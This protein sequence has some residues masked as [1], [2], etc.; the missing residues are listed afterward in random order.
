[1]LLFM[2]WVNFVICTILSQQMNKYVCWK[3][4]WVRMC[5]ILETLLNQDLYCQPFGGGIAG[6]DQEVGWED[7]SRDGTTRRTI[8]I[9]KKDSSFSSVN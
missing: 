8:Q 7:G 3:L 4:V 5:F 6:L 1:M 2:F 9:Y